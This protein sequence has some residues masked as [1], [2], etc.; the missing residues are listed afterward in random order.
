M[1]ARQK[2]RRPSHAHTGKAPLLST[3]S[4]NFPIYQRPPPPAPSNDDRKATNLLRTLVPIAALVGLE[5]PE[6]A[7]TSDAV[8][9]IALGARN[10]PATP[11]TTS[12][13]TTTQHR[14]QPSL[15]RSFAVLAHARLANRQMRTA[16]P[17]TAHQMPW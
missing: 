12:T 6:E 10:H 7:L 14:V 1:H 11:H 9:P 2:T 5:R 17:F 13:P 16:A 15:R 4:S 3:P 8:S